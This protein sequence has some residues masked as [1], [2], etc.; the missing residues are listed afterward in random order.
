[1]ARIMVAIA[2]KESDDK[3]RRLRL[4][5][6][7]KAREG[8]SHGGRLPYGWQPDRTTL[9]PA[10]AQVVRLMADAIIS[11]ESLTGVARHLNATETPTRNGG[12]WRPITVRNILKN[13]RVA[14]YR[15]HNGKV[16][17]KGQWE[18]ILDDDT[19]QTLQR[20]FAR[21]AA[22]KNTTPE[23]KWWVSSVL[24]C[25]TCG[26]R[27]QS[28]P[29]TTGRRYQCPPKLDGCGNGIAAEPIDRIVEGVLLAI[30]NSNEIRIPGQ[31]SVDTVL[32]EQELTAAE[33]RMA[34]LVHDHYVEGWL[35]RG[36]FTAAHGP[37]ETRI[38]ELAA[39]LEQA[40]AT[41]PSSAS[42][43]EAWEQFTPLERADIAQLVYET[44]EIGP[45]NPSVRKFDP[46]RV[47]LVGRNAA[48]NE[49]TQN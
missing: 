24:R 3:S 41:T 8:R 39:K 43:L 19:Y 5:L 15:S 49:Q 48:G 18:P 14:G 33:Q 2:E 29:H 25:G 36:E 35:S 4:V 21:P 13:P 12:P 40:R 32:I 20:I 31:T 22:G 42:I 34:G 47:T 16:V 27:M 11:G 44:V 46:A 23:R 17:G 28:I 30:L 10:E 9:N 45:F 1:M 26:R 7:Q 37:L 38:A 6:G